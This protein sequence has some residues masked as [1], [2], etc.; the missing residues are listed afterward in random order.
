M[1]RENRRAMIAEAAMPMFANKGFKNTTIEDI[2]TACGIAN[3][4]LYLHF[5]NKKEIFELVISGLQEKLNEIVREGIHDK[6]IPGEEYD[7]NDAYN[8]ILNKS[9][10]TCSNTTKTA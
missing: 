10:D 2:C 3:R 7:E 5:K 8:F 6:K 4:T 9:A 1:P